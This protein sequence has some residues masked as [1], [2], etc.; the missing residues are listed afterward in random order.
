MVVVPALDPTNIREPCF[1]LADGPGLPI[2]ES[3]AA[4]ATDLMGLSYGT[5]AAL[6]YREPVH[7]DVPVLI[8]SGHLDPVTPPEWAE[9]VAR[10]LPNNRHVILR[11]GAHLPFALSNVD[12]LDALFVAFL[13]HP[14]PQ[15][16]DISRLE[17]M[18][19]PPF[20]VK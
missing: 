16:L 9:S 8:I 10:H 1:E 13:D 6:V 2:T 7:S 3:A 15:Q 17:Q 18:L 19:P 12:K 20:A 11:H 4:C 14:D 5:R